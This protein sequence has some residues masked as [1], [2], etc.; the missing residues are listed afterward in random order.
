M[1]Q[2]FTGKGIARIPHYDS[3]VTRHVSDRH[4]VAAGSCDRRRCWTRRFACC[5]VAIEC[6]PPHWANA[7]SPCRELPCA[8]ECVSEP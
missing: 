5:G 1:R 2:F 7:Q 6:E 3:G 4:G 8:I